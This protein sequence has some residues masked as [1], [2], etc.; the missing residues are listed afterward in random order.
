MPSRSIVDRLKAGEYIVMD[1]AMGSELQRRG[2]DVDKGCSVDKLGVWSAAA[3]LDAPDVVRAIHEDYLKVG[4][5]IIISNNFF[6][7]KGMLSMIGEQNRWEEYVRRGGELAV[8]ARDAVNPEAYVAGGIAPTFGYQNVNEDC[9]SDLGQEFEAISRILAEAGV[10]FML[11]EYMAGEIVHETP[12]KDCVT[13]V[14]AC[15]KTKLPVFL[16]LNIATDGKKDGKMMHGETYAELVAA[17]KGHRVDGIFLM[18]CDPD[19]VTASLPELRKAFA[20]PIGAYAELG[21]YENPKYGTSPDEKFWLHGIRGITPE[22]YAEYARE[23]KKMGAQIIGGCC[24]S[25][26]KH[27]KAI[28]PVVK[29]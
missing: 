23:W 13:A 14:D 19:E 9:G 4:A 24:S 2:V 27:I 16:G 18:C 28:A 1:G 7:S 21:Y 12:I 29:G 20:G 17:L 15:A 5:E 26:P 10:D 8:A 22:K 25:E 11:P 3:N 6:T